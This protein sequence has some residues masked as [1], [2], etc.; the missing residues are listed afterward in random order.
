MRRRSSSTHRRPRW[1]WHSR[2]AVCSAQAAG[3]TSNP[4][5]AAPGQDILAAYSPAFSNLN[6][7]Q[8]SGTSMSSPHVAGLA[9]LM[10]DRHP[11]WTPMMI[12]SALMTSAYDTVGPTGVPANPNSAL[13]IVSQGAGHV[14]PNNAA[15]PGL[16]F[17][18][19][20]N[21]WLA[22]LCGTTTAVGPR[23]RSA[24]QGRV[25]LDPSDVNVRRLLSAISPAQTVRRRVMNVGSSAATYTPTRDGSGR[26]QRHGRSGE[27]CVE[28]GSERARSP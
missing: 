14:R 1:W 12:K 10:M 18:H 15:D 6:Y 16:V 9:A 19:G 13:T 25:S 8:I 26:I 23:Y 27:S 28:P 17:N 7:N 21:D 2:R 3:I 4:D 24:L 20:F 5:P 22:F 11:S